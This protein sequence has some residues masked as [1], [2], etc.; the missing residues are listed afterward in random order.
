VLLVLLERSEFD[1]ALTVRTSCTASGDV[2]HVG[3]L[4]MTLTLAEFKHILHDGIP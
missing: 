2:L 4:F 1:I 3:A